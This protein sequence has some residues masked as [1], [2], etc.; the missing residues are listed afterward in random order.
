MTHHFTKCNNFSL[1][2]FKNASPQKL[3]RNLFALPAVQA[4]M[5]HH[6]YRSSKESKN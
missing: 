4:D 3:F 5:N 2:F 1:P 6:P